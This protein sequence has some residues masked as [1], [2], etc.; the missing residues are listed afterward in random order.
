M[1]DQPAPAQA[2]PANPPIPRTLAWGAYLAVSWTWCIGMFLPVLLIRDYGQASFLA[3]AI[4][5]ALGAAAMGFV[6]RDPEHS[7]RFVASHRLACWVFSLVT[8]AFQTFFLTWL[9]IPNG[10]S[11]DGLLLAAAAIL[12]IILLQRPSTGGGRML[13]LVSAAFIASV[14]LGLWWLFREGGPRSI[15]DSITSASRPDEILPLA[16][17]CTL[18]FAL[19]P[20]LDLTFHETRQA[21]PRNA[22]RL[23]FGI[24]FCVLFLSMILLTFGYSGTILQQITSQ[25][26]PG[27]Q[28]LPMVLCIHIALQLGCTIAF[29][30]HWAKDPTITR[31]RPMWLSFAAFA[32]GIILGYAGFK[33]SGYAGLDAMELIY[34]CFMAFYGLVFPAYIWT[35]S[36][37]WKSADAPPARVHWTA[38]AAAV[39]IA[40][41][42][43]WLGFI[44]RQTWWLAA[45]VAI[46]VIARPIAALATKLSAPRAN[47]A[48]QPPSA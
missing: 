20:Y 27:P 30:T 46:V 15:P 33:V 47:A 41:P 24:G 25:I 9:L 19:C 17:V 35:C 5:N 23:A 37:P 40:S 28:M 16:M 32:A 26:A 7:R 29:H 45:G 43:Y 36:T 22:G 21:L 39:V 6:L 48:H 8:T 2:N 3:F 31:G 10:Q 18:G 38:L 44:E 34:R 13:A 1:N 11:I 14:A 42:F 4:P 12:P